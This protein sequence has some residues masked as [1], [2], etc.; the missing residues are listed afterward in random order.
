MN[1]ELIK[2]KGYPFN[3]IQ[4]DPCSTISPTFDL[5]DYCC[6]TDILKIPYTYKVLLCFTTNE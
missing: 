3:D 2:I 6:I 5:L 4:T 1:N